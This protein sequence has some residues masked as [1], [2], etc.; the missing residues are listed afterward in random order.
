MQPASA[1]LSLQFVTHIWYM[2]SIWLRARL[3]SDSSI[4]YFSATEGAL[5]CPVG[6]CRARGGSAGPPKQ[7]GVNQQRELP[8][9]PPPFSTRGA[10]FLQKIT[11]FVKT[12]ISKVLFVVQGWKP[13][14]EA[15]APQSSPPCLHSYLLYL[16]TAK[17]ALLPDIFRLSKYFDYVQGRG[18]VDS[19][20]DISIENCL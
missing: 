19:A 10:V 18:W 3:P 8:Y 6:L 12:V 5:V 1:T 14:A 2:F 20:A 9:H 4:H 11:V 15:P 13:S 16:F 17:F 7:R